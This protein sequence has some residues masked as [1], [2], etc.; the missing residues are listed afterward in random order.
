MGGMKLELFS[1]ILDH[2]RPCMHA[3]YGNSLASCDL[4]L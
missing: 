1:A 2:S 4:P 3:N